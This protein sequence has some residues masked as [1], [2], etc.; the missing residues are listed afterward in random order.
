M[1]NRFGKQKKA[2]YPHNLCR[3]E[4]GEGGTDKKQISQSYLLLKRPTAANHQ[5]SGK[6]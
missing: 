4:T 2:T 1:R 6:K 5:A 3:R